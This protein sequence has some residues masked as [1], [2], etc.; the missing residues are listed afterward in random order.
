VP[1]VRRLATALLADPSQPALPPE[2][3]ARLAPCVRL[4]R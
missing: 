3:R 2:L 4:V 1:Q